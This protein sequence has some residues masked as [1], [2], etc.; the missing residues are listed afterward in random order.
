MVI[1]ESLGTVNASAN[2]RGF[3]FVECEVSLTVALALMRL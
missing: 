1:G 2:G 3:V